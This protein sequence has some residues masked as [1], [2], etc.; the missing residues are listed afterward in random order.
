MCSALDYIIMLWSTC[1]HACG[2]HVYM[3]VHV[4][5]TYTSPHYTHC[6]PSPHTDAP[7]LHTDRTKLQHLAT[8]FT[9]LKDREK[10]WTQERKQLTEENTQLTQT[11]QQLAETQNR[12][13]VEKQSLEGE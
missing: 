13:G 5:G 11:L 7:S 2:L 12:V 3:H 4:A 10:Q 9:D 6:H 1:V 8:D